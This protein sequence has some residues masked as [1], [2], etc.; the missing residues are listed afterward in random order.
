MREFNLS[1]LTCTLF[2]LHNRISKFLK[3][4]QTTDWEIAPAIIKIDQ[5]CPFLPSSSFSHVH[6]LNLQFGPAH[7]LA[8]RATRA[9]GATH[10]RRSWR[11]TMNRPFLDKNRYYWSI[12]VLPLFVCCEDC[13]PD[14]TY[15][16]AQL[17]GPNVIRIWQQQMR[18][19]QQPACCVAAYLRDSHCKLPLLYKVAS[20]DR[21]WSADSY[22]SLPW[23]CT[24]AAT[25]G[26]YQ[27]RPI[28]NKNR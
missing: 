22:C 7:T 2:S 4:D 28:L 27:I 21:H 5:Y 6:H 18:L 20:I 3:T 15:H 26:S 17:Q 1:L 9:T 24:T 14:I 25:F 19:F 13:L 23:R 16:D 8:T 12:S 11:R 10:G